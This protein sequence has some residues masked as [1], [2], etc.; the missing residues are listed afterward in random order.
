MSQ[1]FSPSRA[2]A[3]WLVIDYDTLLDNIART[4]EKAVFIDISLPLFQRIWHYMEEDVIRCGIRGVICNDPEVLSLVSP[5]L[6]RILKPGFKNTETGYAVEGIIPVLSSFSDC[7][8]LSNMAQMVDKRLC[9]L[10]RARSLSSEFAGG[11]WGI[12]DL[13]MRIK[14]LPM[15]DF[16]GFFLQRTPDIS[17]SAFL[18]NLSKDCRNLDFSCI[19]PFDQSCSAG[20]ESVSYSKWENLA[21]CENSEGI[22]PVEASFWAY[23]VESGADYQIY[24]LDLGFSDGLPESFPVKVAGN[25]AG[26][27]N[28]FEN[29][30]E[31]IIKGHFQGPYPARGCMAGGA[32]HNP[33]DLQ[34]W[35]TKDLRNFLL[36]FRDFPVYLR[37]KNVFQEILP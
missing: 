21:L 26:I 30:C 23:P 24:Q 3:C 2:F 15:I 37:K 16:S 5:Q 12:E 33:V 4:A 20:K 17:E 19:F 11:D 35:K 8:A 18:K 9:F 29:H 36:H 32:A 34:A 28:I 27:V 31:L 25:D 22:F 7:L 1:S 10:L 13:S 6:T 14:Q